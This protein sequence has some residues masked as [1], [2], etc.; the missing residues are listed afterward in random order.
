MLGAL[1]SGRFGG[2]EEE[3]GR[4]PASVLASGAEV[5]LRTGER[6]RRQREERGK[7]RRPEGKGDGKRQQWHDQG[8]GGIISRGVSPWAC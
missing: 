2:V 7:E 6:V 8:N 4:S 1:T 3:V 5:A